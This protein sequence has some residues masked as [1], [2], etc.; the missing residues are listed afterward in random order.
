MKEDDSNSG[1]DERNCFNMIAKV[2]Q[3]RMAFEFEG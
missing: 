2:K 3:K 1:N